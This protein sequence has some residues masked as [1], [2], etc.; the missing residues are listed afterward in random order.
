MPVVAAAA[1]AAALQAGGAAN[2]NPPTLTPFQHRRR[3]PMPQQSLTRQERALTSHRNAAYQWSTD[4]RGTNLPSFL[5]KVKEG[6][7]D[8]ARMLHLTLHEDDLNWLEEHNGHYQFYIHPR[9][10]KAADI[11]KK[12]TENKLKSSQIMLR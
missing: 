7:E 12:K 5:D 3:A 9:S 6:I 11:L 10:E 4:V 2:P 1:A 8:A